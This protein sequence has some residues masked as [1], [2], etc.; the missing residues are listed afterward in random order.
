MIRALHRRLIG[1]EPHPELTS[2]DTAGVLVRVAVNWL[3]GW[4]WRPF[5]ARCDG[6]L[7]VARG[8]RILGPGRLTVGRRV[9]LEEHVELQARSRRGVRL[10]AGVTIGRGA[11]IR[12]SSYYGHEP[13]EGL[14]VGDGTAIGAGVWIGASGFV[15]IGRDVLFG[16]GVTILPENHV[17]DDLDATIKSQGVER[18]G[19]V[20]EDDCWI[21]ARAVLLAGVRVGRGAVVAAGAVV[22]RDVAPFA[23][24]GGVPAG[25]LRMR[26]ARREEAA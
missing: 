21:G 2:R 8:A 16:P 11:S 7:L 5:L 19:V 24:V 9:K 15:S 6:Q 1:Q 23:V 20:V 26:G 25:V 4:R 14:E 13:G 22:T 10:G 18:A 17:F 12:P 3:R